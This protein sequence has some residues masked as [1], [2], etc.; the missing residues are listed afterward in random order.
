[1]WYYNSQVIK[2]PKTMV[3]DN[4]TYPRAIFRN[5]DTLTSLSIKP[6]RMITP[7][8]RYYTTGAYTLDES[9]DEVVGTYAGTAIDIATLKARMLN[10]INSEVDSKQSAIDWY[11]SRADKGGT[12]VPANIA[13]YATTIY[14]EQVTKEG[15]VN[16]MT[17]LDEIMEYENR[18]YTEVRKTGVGDET[19]S[20]AREINMLQHWTE[21]PDA[22][23]DP[24]FVSLTAD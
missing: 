24:L 15:E 6:Y 5:S 21:H 10:V 16:A 3:I 13:T 14:S 17:T 8:S 23:V 9:G 2:T 22:P 4:I 18:P 11:W 12:A 20:S 7:D 19:V 1:M